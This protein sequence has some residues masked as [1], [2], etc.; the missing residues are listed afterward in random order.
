MVAPT[1]QHDSLRDPRFLTALVVLLVND[2]VLKAVWPGFVS[3]K[4]SDLAG[5]VFFPVVIA[6]MFALV[7][8]RPRPGIVIGAAAVWFIGLQVNVTIDGLHE[9]ALSF[10]L[11]WD[12]VNTMDPTDLIALVAVPLSA[13]VLSSPR[14]ITLQVGARRAVVACVLLGCLAET[15]PDSDTIGP[16]ILNDNGELEVLREGDFSWQDGSTIDVDGPLESI[17]IAPIGFEEFEST[18]ETFAGARE[19]C[20]T[21][22]SSRCFRLGESVFVVEES[23]DGGAS[24]S[25]SW[26]INEDRYLMREQ[27]NSFQFYD[28]RQRGIVVLEDDVVFVTTAIGPILTW[29]EADGWTPSPRSLRTVLWP[30]FAAAAALATAALLLPLL[31]LGLVRSLVGSVFGLFASL[32]TALSSILD[33][34]GAFLVG[35][36]ALGAGTVFVV[37][38]VAGLADTSSW[39][40]RLLDRRW[41]AAIVVVAVVIGVIP[42]LWWLVVPTLALSPSLTALAVV[43]GPVAFVIG[44][45]IDQ[46]SKAVLRSNSPAPG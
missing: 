24:W 34:F 6:S 32:A 13:R 8:V 5:L 44:V 7:R 23:S 46:K 27:G 16:P 14:P 30:Y 21:S 41:V 22:T 25:S 31:G 40:A 33:S 3:G 42:L 11:P 36:L 15:G 17:T 9:T 10:L 20:L 39:N 38:F 28:E 1:D 4:L 37:F 26:A 19:A 29:T 12:V 18:L 45:G 43:G 2:L 35:G